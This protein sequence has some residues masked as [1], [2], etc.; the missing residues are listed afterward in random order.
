MGINIKIVSLQSSFK[1]SRVSNFIELLFWRITN[2]LFIEDGVKFEPLPPINLS[3]LD[4][5][6]C[7]AF[8]EGYG[9]DG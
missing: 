2:D 4:E 8:G 6:T 1:A 9:M 5:N 3:D 7:A